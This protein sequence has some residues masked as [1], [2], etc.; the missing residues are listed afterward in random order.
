LGINNRDLTNGK[1]DL[2]ISRRLLG[3]TQGMD[4][5]C[6]VCE[7]GIHTRE[8]IEGFEKLGMHAF[9]IGESLM[10]APS[11][12]EKLQELLGYGKTSVSG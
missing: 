8:D 12:P 3:L 11:I 5:L 2:D 9:L 6:L 1:T 7:S 10:K 4:G